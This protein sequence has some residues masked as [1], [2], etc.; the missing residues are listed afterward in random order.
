MKN[1]ENSSLCGSYQQMVV[2]LREAQKYFI[3]RP[4]NLEG[5]LRETIGKALLQ[6]SKPAPAGWRIEDYS[7]RISACYLLSDEHGKLMATVPAYQENDEGRRIADLIVKAV[8][9]VAQSNF[10]AS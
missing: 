2:A 4:G 1:T 8:A 10:G 9:A 5:Q 7:K 6:P 3:N